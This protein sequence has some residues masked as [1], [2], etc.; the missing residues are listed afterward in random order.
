MIIKNKLGDKMPIINSIVMGKTGVGKSTLINSIF[1]EDIMETGSGRPVTDRIKMIE[2]EGYPIRLYDTRGLEL[3]KRGQDEAINEVKM[4]L[5][6]KAQ[7]GNPEE[8]IHYIWYCINSRSNRVEEFELELIERI[9]RY[10]EVIVVLTQSIGNNWKELE[11]K[12]IERN[13]PIS[14]IIPILS[15]D[16]E[17]TDVQKIDAFGVEKLIEKSIENIDKANAKAAAYSKF[18][19]VEKKAVQAKKVIKKHV[20]LAFGTGITPIPFQDAMLLVPNQILMINRINKEMGLNLDKESIKLLVAGLGGTIGATAVGRTAVSS[21]FKMIPGI[22]TVA[23]S[24]ISGSTAAFLTSA[25]GLAYI[26]TAS[27]FLRNKYLGKTINMN[28]FSAAL[29]KKYSEYIKKG[30]KALKREV[31]K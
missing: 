15:K 25:L 29:K 4:I 22:G 20:G 7:T 24:A 12:L 28:E 11:K 23:G 31:N 14:N 17:I 13:L 19:L 18:E 27:A 8:F 30:K 1:E 5:K 6:E 16:Y 9:S 2:K 3:E 26:E 10:S 21:A